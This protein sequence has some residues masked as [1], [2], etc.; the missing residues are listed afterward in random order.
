MKA[1]WS[2]GELRDAAVISMRIEFFNGIVRFLYHS[3]AFLCTS[4]TIRMLKL[5]TVAYVTQCRT[6]RHIRLESR[7]KSW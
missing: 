5:Y 6:L 3:T 1:V 4:V 7:S 2:Q